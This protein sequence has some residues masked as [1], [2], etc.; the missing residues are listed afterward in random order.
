MAGVLSL[1]SNLPLVYCHSRPLVETL[2]LRVRLP[3][4]SALES[5]FKCNT[6]VGVNVVELPGVIKNLSSPPSALVLSA[7][8]LA[9]TYSVFEELASIFLKS[10]LPN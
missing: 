9:P 3:A 10:I 1:K 8:I 5:F 6:G 7:L 4:N 2:A